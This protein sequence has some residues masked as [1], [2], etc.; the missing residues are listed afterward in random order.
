LRL[1]LPAI[2]Q[3]SAVTGAEHLESGYLHYAISNYRLNRRLFKLP[4]PTISTEAADVAVVTGYKPFDSV[5]A[6][7]QSICDSGLLL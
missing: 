2:L 6:A 1:H 3:N 4:K 7:E 5:F